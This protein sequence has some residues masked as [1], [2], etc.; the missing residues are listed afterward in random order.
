MTERSPSA[1]PD[2]DAHFAEEPAAAGNRELATASPPNPA[3]VD[4]QNRYGDKNDLGLVSEPAA[5][6]VDD[7]EVIACYERP[8]D[9]PSGRRASPDTRRRRPVATSPASASKNRPGS[10]VPA[11]RHDSPTGPAAGRPRPLSRSPRRPAPRP[12]AHG[13]PQLSTTHAPRVAGSPKRPLTPVSPP[14]RGPRPPPDVVASPTRAAVRGGRLHR[15]ARGTPHPAVT[16]YHQRPPVR[17]TA[18]TTQRATRR[19]AP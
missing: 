3:T 2:I 5:V 12:R 9:R 17:H 13:L 1:Q 6:T 14:L 11:G 16:V 4:P 7:G 10:Y 19:P 15:A 8:P 18:R